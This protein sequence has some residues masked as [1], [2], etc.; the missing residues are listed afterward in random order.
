MYG[1]ENEGN[2]HSYVHQTWRRSQANFLIFSEVQRS[3]RLEKV[4]PTA[5]EFK[6]MC[7]FDPMLLT[8]FPPRWMPAKIVIDAQQ[9]NIVERAGCD[10]SLVPELQQF[11]TDTVTRVKNTSTVDLSC[12]NRRLNEQESRRLQESRHPEV[13]AALAALQET[14]RHPLHL[15]EQMRVAEAIQTIHTHAASRGASSQPRALRQKKG[16]GGWPRRAAA[17][18]IQRKAQRALQ[19][20][21]G[22]T[23][24]SSADAS[25]ATA[26]TA[27][28][29]GF[30]PYDAYDTYGEQPIRNMCEVTEWAPSDDECMA[31]V[32]TYGCDP[33]YPSIC[34]DGPL[35]GQTGYNGEGTLGEGCPIACGMP[36]PQHGNDYEAEIRDICELTEWAPTDHECYIWANEKYG[37]GSSYKQICPDG[38]LQ[39]GV[40]YDGCPCRVDSRRAVREETSQRKVGLQGVYSH[41]LMKWNR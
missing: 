40:L 30:E 11:W 1:Y 2:L 21:T 6:S 7:Q 5:E 26:A 20:A 16:V 15:F 39:D 36:H 29:G 25:D 13:K 23:S 34:P 22:S 18:T 9:A 12:E 19:S 37:C 3:G 28:Y 14:P 10:T 35:A 38:P 24:T 32:A 33:T 4:G 17:A 31:W 27:A 8:R 41:V